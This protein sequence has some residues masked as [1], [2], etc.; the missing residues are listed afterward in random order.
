[1]L[2]TTPITHTE[3]LGSG[4]AFG[5]KVSDV[6]NYQLINE[7]TARPARSDQLAAHRGRAKRRT[8]PRAD[9]CVAGKRARQAV[10]LSLALTLALGLGLGLGPS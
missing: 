1:M 4:N 6:S 5:R 10:T 8:A 7:L 2:R 3:P 9:L